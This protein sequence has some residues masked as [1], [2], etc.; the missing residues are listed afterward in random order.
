MMA[1]GDFFLTFFRRSSISFLLACSL[2][3]AQQGTSAAGQK[4]APSAPAQKASPTAELTKAT[5]SRPSDAPQV[6][7]QLNAAM[8]DLVQKVSPAVVQIQVTG[9]GPIEPSTRGETALIARQNAIGSGIIVDPTGYII[10]NAH[11]VEGARRIRVV[12]SPLSQDTGQLEPVGK[13]QVMEAKLIGLHKDSD[14]ALLKVEGKDLPTLELG[15]GRRVRQGQL[16]FAIGSPEGLQNSVTMGV[17]SSV[18]RQPDPEKPM[19]YLQ[20]DAPI[21]PGNSGG[22]LVDMDGYVLG[23]NTMILS[24][25]GGSEG[26]GFAIP[27]RVVRFVYES[28]RKYGH[29]HRV[30]IEAGAQ[31]ITPTMAEG[32]KLSQSYGV[33]IADVSPDGP[34]EAAGLKIGDIVVSADDRPINTLPALTAA[35]YLHPVDQVMKLVVLRGGERKTLEV[36]VIEHRDQVDKLMDAVDPDKSLIDRLGVLA[37]DLNDQLKSMVSGLRIQS[38]VVV[39]ARAA[40]LIG[41]DTG[42]KTGDIIHSMNN[43][44]IDSVDALRAS[45]RGLKPGAPVVLQV[46]RD[47]GLEWVG[48]D[49]E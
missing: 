1:V 23:V 45:L 43:T 14:L 17:I 48:F 38:G 12:F 42:L 34:A 8:E 37:I 36:P 44:P 9:F 19:V 7:Q 28:L 29:V 31:T 32:L 3:V 27:A 21:N 35:M 24:Q 4:S 49:L 13:Q 22:P 26:L 46:E 6:L 16:V 2:A 10:T 18:G 40:N 15:S 5:S 11:V 20:T 25:G 33:I 30:E 47:G 39:I 41:P